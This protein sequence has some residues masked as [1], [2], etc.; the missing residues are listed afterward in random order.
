MAST[1]DGV[2]ALLVD[3][4][5]EITSADC[6]Q[7]VIA[8]SHASTNAPRYALSVKLRG[9]A[10]NDAGIGKENAGIA[11]FPTLAEGGLA[12]VAVSHD[13]ARI[14]DARDVFANGVVSRVNEAAEKIGVKPGITIAE[15]VALVNKAVPAPTEP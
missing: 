15:Y 3:S 12:A 2:E 13:T 5:S 6:G 7:I 1:P 8:G 10:F 9:A 11:S 14:G 4:I